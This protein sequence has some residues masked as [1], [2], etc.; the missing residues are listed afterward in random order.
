MNL[1]YKTIVEKVKGKNRT[2][3]IKVEVYLAV[4]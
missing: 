1:K 2:I 4:Y 3:T